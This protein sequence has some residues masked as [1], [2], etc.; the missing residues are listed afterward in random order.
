MINPCKECKCCMHFINFPT[1]CEGHTK[2]YF[3]FYA[4]SEDK[5]SKE[6]KKIIMKLIGGAYDE[7]GWINIKRYKKEWEVK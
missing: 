1:E 4:N 7:D 5:E 3:K 2:P 6:I